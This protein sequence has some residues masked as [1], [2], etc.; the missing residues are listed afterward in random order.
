[1]AEFFIVIGMVTCIY[2]VSLIIATF[3]KKDND[4][5]IF[6]EAVGIMVSLGVGVCIIGAFIG[7]IGK[8]LGLF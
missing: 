3:T 2:V 8:I 1:M 5:S 4:T 7:I 6:L